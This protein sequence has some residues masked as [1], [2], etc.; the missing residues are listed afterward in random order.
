VADLHHVRLKRQSEV[1]REPERARQ[2]AHQAWQLGVLEFSL[3]E[4]ADSVI[5]HST[6]E[7]QWLRGFPGIGD[8]GKVHVVPWSVAAEPVQRS[9]DKRSGVAF[10]GGFKHEP[11]VDAARWLVNEVMPLVWRKAPQIECLLVGSDM[12]QEV[13]GWQR[14]GIEVLGR[15]DDLTE[16]FERARLTVAPLRFGAGVKDKVLRS[17]GAGLPCVGT[18]LAFEGMPRLP[19]ALTRHC[20]HDTASGLA[21]AIVRMHGEKATNASCADAGLNYV[22]VNYNK[23]DVN[24]L[25]RQVAQPAL[26]SHRTVTGGRHSPQDAQADVQE[27]R[28]RGATVLVFGT[29]ADGAALKREEPEIIDLDFADRKR[30]VGIA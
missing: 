20:M 9:F 18:A 19:A 21:A 4:S 10:I 1:E 3:A 5:T 17:L 12:P 25:M 26:K 15:V 14:P 29:E 22:G 6:T 11:N 28:S 13:L 2:L 27:V 30:R 8:N 24:S 7:A 16:V 23:A